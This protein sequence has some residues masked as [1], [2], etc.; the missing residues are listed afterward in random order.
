MKGPEGAL[1]GPM[2]KTYAF[3]LGGALCLAVTLAPVL[4][5]YLF[6][7]K[8]REKDT[9]VDRLMKRSYLRNL[10]RVLRFR[11]L[12]LLFTG[13]LTAFTIALIPSLGGEFMPPLEEG[14]L[15]IRA[16]MPRTS[17]LEQAARLGPELRAVIAGIPEV[18]AVMSHIGRPDDGT[19]V[20]GLFNLEF[21]VPLKPMEEWRKDQ[22]GRP[23][24]REVIQN[25]LAEKFKEFPGLNVN[26]SQLIRDNVEEALSG[27][28]GAN[29]VKLIGNDLKQLEEYGK[30]V[31]GILKKV[32][33]IQNAG[34]F[35]VLGQPNLEIKIKREQCARYG[36]SVADAESAVQVAIG[37]RAFSQ[38]VEGE[39]LFD[40]V[41]R[42][43]FELRDDPAVIARIPIDTHGV[44]DQPGMRIPLSQLATIEPHR[45]GASYIYRENN[46]RYIPIKFSVQG[47]DLA[48]TIAE[49]KRMVED[50]VTGAKLTGGL[51]DRMVG[52]IRPD[53]RGQ[54]QIC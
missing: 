38:M 27:V 44:G 37:G 35:H 47:R 14:N 36:V 20:T 28:K 7:D 45:T 53:A 30:R 17:S 18:K 5:S 48:S 22:W 15:W 42:L 40:V 2:A 1:F 23:I 51:S 9:I 41:L 26:F 49:A 3:A 50:P 16:I 25:E 21:N 11:R 12:T 29:S 34:L 39:K 6:H 33:G 19:D 46:R 13:G 52:R 8:L 31:L 32:P 43:P 4:C 54:C 24:S 10:D